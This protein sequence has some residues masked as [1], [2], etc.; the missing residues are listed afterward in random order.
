MTEGLVDDVAR[1]VGLDPFEIRRRNIITQDMY[2]YTSPTGYK[3]ERLSHEQC[4]D[5]LHDMM[6]YP[7]LVK[8]QQELRE[9]GIYRGI[10]IAMFVEITNQSPPFYGVKAARVFPR[11]MAPL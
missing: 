9:K 1:R 7:Q 10:G 6:D 8:E 4:L 5:K 11:R 3:F 2:P